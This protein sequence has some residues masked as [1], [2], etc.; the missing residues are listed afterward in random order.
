MDLLFSLIPGALKKRGLAEHAEG[1]LIVHRAQ[2][3][4]QEKCP[5]LLECVKVRSIKDH[6]LTIE[7]T[8]SVALQECQACSQDL[9]LYLQQECPFGII[10]NVRLLRQ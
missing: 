9:L 8:H 3:W 10:K 6:V 1:A 4:L 5:H 7:C 2:K